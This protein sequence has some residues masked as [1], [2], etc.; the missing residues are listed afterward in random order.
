MIRWDAQ[1]VWRYSF[2]N[3]SSL[4][5]DVGN[6]LI[7]QSF[8][9]LLRAA[10]FFWLLFFCFRWY[11]LVLRWFFCRSDGLKCS[12]FL[13]HLQFV[14]FCDCLCLPAFALLVFH[15][16]F[17]LVFKRGHQKHVGTKTRKPAEANAQET[18]APADQRIEDY[19]VTQRG[20]RNT[21]TSNAVAWLFFFEIAPNTPNT[22]SVASPSSVHW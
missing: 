3:G 18:R 10:C 14:S 7:L 2:L 13:V 21:K 6:K 16:M 17:P 8:L 19:F 4:S 20:W 12:V 5:A 1:D 11:V 22:P 15:F 9:V